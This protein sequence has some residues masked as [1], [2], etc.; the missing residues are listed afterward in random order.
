M[1]RLIEQLIEEYIVEIEKMAVVVNNTSD[2]EEEVSTPFEVGMTGKI[3][4]YILYYGNL[5][6]VIYFIKTRSIP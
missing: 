3:K 2:F 4:L 1:E 6:V 5:L